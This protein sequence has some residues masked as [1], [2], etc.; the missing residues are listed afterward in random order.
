MWMRMMG[1]PLPHFY[2]SIGP[3][4]IRDGLTSA[5]AGLEELWTSAAVSS[6]IGV[7][8]DKFA[9]CGTFQDTR[10]TLVSADRVAVGLHARRS[11]CST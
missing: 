11:F 3:F 8:S 6:H 4:K 7:L 9:T 10:C 1:A 2:P 5:R